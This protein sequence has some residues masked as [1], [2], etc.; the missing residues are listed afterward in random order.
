MRENYGNADPNRTGVALTTT[1]NSVNILIP[2][3]SA[4]YDLNDQFMLLA[5]VHRGFTPPGPGSNSDPEDSTNW[6]A[7]FRWFGDQG[8]A[9][10]IGFYSDYDNLLGTCTASTGGNCTI[11]D[12]FDGG[13]VKVI[14]V[15]ASYDGEFDTPWDGVTAPVSANYTWTQTEFQNSFNSSFDPWGAVTAGDELPYIPAHQFS[16]TA[17]LRS[18]VWRAS[19]TTNYVSE[20]RSHAGQGSIPANE[21]I[22][23]RWVTDAAVG[24]QLTP[25][26]ELYARVD[27]VFDET[28]LAARRPAGLRPGQPRTVMV[29]LRISFGGI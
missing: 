4:T 3:I 28:Y 14:G 17:G 11:G 16:V 12:Q 18:D 1:S 25:G 19:L 23:D 2:G 27:N 26:T 13:E 22:D 8:T 20:T 24:Y 5:G 21:R 7:G 9:A 29:G 15:E 10:V 6:E